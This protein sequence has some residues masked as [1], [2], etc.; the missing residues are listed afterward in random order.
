MYELSRVNSFLPPRREALQGPPFSE[1]PR[2][3]VFLQ[4]AEETVPLPGN[5]YNLGEVLSHL[6]RGVDSALKQEESVE[7]ALRSGAQ[8]ATIAISGQ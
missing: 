3:L 8:Q 4:A 1:D 2:W 5:T 7:G 6:S